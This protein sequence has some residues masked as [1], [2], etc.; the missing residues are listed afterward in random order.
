[1]TRRDFIGNALAALGFSALPGGF[2]FAVPPGW[3]PKGKPNLVFGV[4][5]DTHL[6]TAWDGKS[7]DRNYTD[8]YFLLG[9]TDVMEQCRGGKVG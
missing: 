1:M 9:R 2:L 5:S 3:K 4:V 7:V 6:R 8:K